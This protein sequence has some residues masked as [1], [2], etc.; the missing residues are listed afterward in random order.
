MQRLAAAE[1]SAGEVQ[2][3]MSQLQIRAEEGERRLKEL[4]QQRQVRVGVDSAGH[5]ACHLKPYINTSAAGMVIR[6]C[7][8]ALHHR[9][10]MHH[11]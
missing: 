10:D 11:F 2:T 9:R 1:K 6:D 8:L 3:Q 4:T 5:A 7:T